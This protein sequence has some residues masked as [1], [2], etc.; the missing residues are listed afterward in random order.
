MDPAGKNVEVWM[1]EL[2]AAMRDSVKAALYDAVIDYMEAPRV[3][4]IQAWPGQCVL[5]GSAMHW[6]REVEEALAESG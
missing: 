5:N 3:D 1:T 6:T 4:W 2:E